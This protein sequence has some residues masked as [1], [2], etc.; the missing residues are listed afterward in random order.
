MEQTQLRP[1]TDVSSDEISL[2]DIVAFIAGYWL[3]IAVLAGIG[4]AGGAVYTLSQ[5]DQYQATATLVVA[6]SR[7][8]TDVSRP[9]LTI[10]AYQR[11]LESDYIIKKT[12]EKLLSEKSVSKVR[13]S[14]ATRV[15]SSTRPDESSV[16][17]ASASGD[18]AED[19][20]KIAD[21]WIKVFLDH[22]K[23]IVSERQSMAASIL[24]G[25]IASTRT[26]LEKL[27]A[28]R[29]AE[30]DKIRGKLAEEIL[31]IERAIG[32]AKSAGEDK[33][34]ALQEEISKKIVAAKSK[35]NLEAREAELEALQRAY[36]DLQSESA[37]L[38]G[39]LES[40]RLMLE[41]ARK[42][43]S[44]TPAVLVT[45]KAIPD[46]ALW[47]AMSEKS[48]LD[49]EA[50]KK[51]GLV[52][53]QPNPLYG[54]IA[55]K[56]AFYEMEVNTLAPRQEKLKTELSK[57][58]EAVAKLG[59]S[60]RATHAEVEQLE[61]MLE[62]GTK[63]IKET[64]SSEVSAL[65]KQ[66]DAEIKEGERLRAAGV[67]S[68]ERELVAQRELFDQLSKNWNSIN[69]SKVQDDF[70][71]LRVGASPV[72][73]VSPVA[74]KTLPVSIAAAIG[75]AL[76]GIFFSLIHSIK[77]KKAEAERVLTF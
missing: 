8:R 5:P 50:L 23:E 26:Q 35:G 73:P 65:E 58:A 48:A 17:E 39:Q 70:D 32:V 54:E 38:A 24:S 22:I 69:I 52:S 62:T 66:R 67:A 15:I 11:L 16:L 25:Q 59:D 28:D 49:P 51:M 37:R 36:G 20:A 14:F 31:K 74:R 46:E 19:S 56:A 2:A 43:L 71:D 76:A 41:A 72:V 1:K 63:K 53:E 61:A 27:D 7:Q 9:T 12:R 68:I 3:P 34:F 42:Q 29:R 6:P 64:T 47:R 13:T 44:Q 21:A 57:M 60:V 30:Q 55:R 75:G 77:R 18:T 10:N 33:K 4:A 40:Q 45:R